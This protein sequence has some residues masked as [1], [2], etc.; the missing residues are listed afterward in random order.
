MAPKQLSV[1][2]GKKVFTY[3]MVL[4][5]FC[6]LL[7]RR[8]TDTLDHMVLAVLW[9][10]SKSGRQLS[11]AATETLGRDISAADVP[12][13]N[14]RRLQQRFNSL[15]VSLINAEQQLIDQRELI[16]RLSAI[17]QH[18]GLA[19]SKLIEAQIVGSDTS[20]VR[21]VKHMQILD[22]GSLNHIRPGRLALASV[23]G[24]SERS[25]SSDGL[26]VEQPDHSF[27]VV[28]KVL[29]C[30]LGT[31]QL[32]ILNDVE[33]S[34]PV[35]IQPSG[36]RQANWRAEGLLAGTSSGTMEVRLISTSY[37]VAPGD[38][39]LACSN[40]RYLPVAV[41]AGF[42]ESC[43]RDG[44]NPVL[45]RI[46]ARAATDLHRLSSVVVVDTQSDR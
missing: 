9:P 43:V 15:E 39:I 36:G 8:L 24:Y 25:R 14:Y 22:R 6:T 12:A 7:P 4:A 42:V 18:F 38:A 31:S 45:W 5:F 17:R 27:C 44:T 16:D 34:L 41:L 26:P 46:T 3:L 10:F 29:S 11:L 28:G 13:E 21:Q 2:T 37:P 19:R 40:P 35:F 20:N 33:F 30:G 32:Q 1:V 23:S